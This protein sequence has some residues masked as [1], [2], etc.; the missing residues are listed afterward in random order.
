MSMDPCFIPDGSDPKNL[1]G[2]LGERLGHVGEVPDLLQTIC[3]LIVLQYQMQVIP[4]RDAV[5]CQP[6]N[7]VLVQ[8]DDDSAVKGMPAKFRGDM[9]V[10]EPSPLSWTKRQSRRKKYRTFDF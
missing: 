2:H 10:M 8:F 1:L 7:T 9:M 4:M 3:E 6:M 5:Y